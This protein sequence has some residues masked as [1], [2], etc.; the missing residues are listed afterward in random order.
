MDW[1]VGNELFVRLFGLLFFKV[2]HKRIGPTTSVWS[3]PIR[4]HDIV[5]LRWFNDEIFAIH[6]GNCECNTTFEEAEVIAR[7]CEEMKA[8]RD[9]TLYTSRPARKIIH[10]GPGML[11]TRV[12]HWQVVFEECE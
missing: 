4:E 2:G 6:A 12:K 3:W 10:F 5:E 7:K 8:R 9:Y 11:N 1:F